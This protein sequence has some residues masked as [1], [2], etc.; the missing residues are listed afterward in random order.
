MN[1]VL[2]QFME[3]K[4]VN[5]KTEK[6]IH[7]IYAEIEGGNYKLAMEKISRLSEMTSENHPD[8]IMARM[9]LRRRMR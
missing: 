1:A 2:E 3:T 9:E 7:S 5:A 8:V 6:L 4:S